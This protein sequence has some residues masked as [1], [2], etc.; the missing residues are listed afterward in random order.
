MPRKA[1][2]AK[3][4]AGW[5]RSRGFNGEIR[6]QGFGEGALAVATADETNELRNRRAKY[7]LAA[8]EPARSGDI[9][10]S[11]WKPGERACHGFDR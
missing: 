9:P 3:T 5:F 7:V 6:Y 1:R 11:Q 2:G 10:R 8:E 4:I